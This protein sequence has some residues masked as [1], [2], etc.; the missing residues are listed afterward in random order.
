MPST[1]QAGVAT[2]DITPAVGF[3][4]IAD[5]MRLRPAEGIADPL[6]AKT[7]VLSDGVTTA[8]LVTA[9]LLWFTGELVA[10]IRRD[11]ER[12]TGIPGQHVILNASHTHASAEV[13]PEYGVSPEYLIELGRKVAG[14]ILMAQR[15]MQPA[16]VG[17][18]TGS[19]RMTV[20]RWL[21]TGDSCVW[22]P[23]PEGP[24]DDEVGVLR[25]DAEDGKPVAVLVNFA[26]HT[27]MLTAAIMQY[28]GDYAGHMATAVESH[29]GGDVTAM[30][31]A[32]AG[33]DIK[34][35]KEKP[36]GTAFVIATPEDCRH[37]GGILAAEACRV[38]EGISTAEAQTLR[39]VVTEVE[40][41]L[42]PPFSVEAY[43]R[44]AAE[45][46]ATQPVPPGL[47]FTLEWAERSA[48]MVR[49]GSAPRSLRVELQLLCIGDEIALFAL[50]GELFVE[51]GKSIKDA[52]GKPGA[53]V[54]AY[55]NDTPRVGYLPSKLAASWGWCEVDHQ[56]KYYT[57]P[58]LPSNFSGEVH[59]VLAEAAA[60]MVAE[61]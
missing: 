20:N 3:D 42:V 24:V 36:E 29:F 5:F 46:R 53:F 30:F 17:S 8:A 55:C 11:V 32:G 23:N 19:A 18:G 27:S 7:L 21:P 22:A 25:V 38:A 41:P 12:L 48:Q 60:R 31:C 40:L 16:R 33:G 54:A 10:S 39:V 6:R 9:D 45:I 1:L 44:E 51:V 4:N 26:A 35:S 47:A 15:R 50:P 37:Y 61:A 49:E 58:I 43:E 34:V 57:R 56:L 59:D 14:A 52:L 28:S 13:S 2:V